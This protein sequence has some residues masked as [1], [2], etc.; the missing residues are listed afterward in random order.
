[1]AKAMQIAWSPGRS[2]FGLVVMMFMIGNRLTIFSIFF[3]I[4]VLTGPV[5][6]LMNVNGGA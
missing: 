1:M 3:L 6:Q 2:L 4:P 5:N